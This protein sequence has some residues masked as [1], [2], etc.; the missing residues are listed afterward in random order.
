MGITTQKLADTL[1]WEWDTY[2]PGRLAH[3]ADE[4]AV[5]SDAIRR[6]DSRKMRE[7]ISFIRAQPDYRPRFAVDGGGG[8]NL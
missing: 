3:P 6:G 8:A 7:L 2:G 1:L 5:I 4:E